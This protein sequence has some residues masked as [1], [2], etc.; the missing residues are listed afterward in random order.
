[1]LIQV[2]WEFN[3]L[4]LHILIVHSVVVGI[5]LAAL[6]TILSAVWPAARRRLG[7]VTPIVALF[8][9]AATFSAQQAGEWLQ[10]RVSQTPRIQTHTSLGGTMLWFSLGL[11]VAALLAWGVPFLMSRQRRPVPTW[12]TVAV[13]VV[14]VG[15]S[16]AAAVQVFRVGES[17]ST[18]VWT[19]SYCPDP[20]NPN[21][22]C[23]AFQ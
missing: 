16:A 3:G 14:A 13:A 20:V 4:P 7:I 18:A 2:N 15:L 8:A 9:L 5:P 23:P 21:G 17:G 10:A 19:D 22:T 1:M 12:M 6:L 11:F